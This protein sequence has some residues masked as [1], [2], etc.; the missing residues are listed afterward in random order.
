MGRE[1][2]QL[3]D[4]C[5]ERKVRFSPKLSTQAGSWLQHNSAGR[6]S[7]LLPYLQYGPNNQY[8]QLMEAAVAARA[9]GRSLAVPRFHSWVNDETGSCETRLQQSGRN[10][11]CRKQSLALSV[12][13]LCHD[14][15]CHFSKPSV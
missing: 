9:L 13:H 7:L 11:H 12:R 15:Q 6:A 8:L 10:P 5:A 1:R 4:L 14:Q 3:S 2:L